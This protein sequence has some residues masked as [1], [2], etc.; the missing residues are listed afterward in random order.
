MPHDASLID[1]INLLIRGG[2]YQIPADSGIGDVFRPTAKGQQGGRVATF[3]TYFDYYINNVPP[4]DE[5]KQLNPNIEYQIRL[6]PDVVA[7][8]N[9]RMFTVASMP[10]RVEANP[11]ASDK[12]AAET[13]AEHCR[14]VIKAI[15]NF[16]QCIEMMEWAV[17]VGGQGLEFLWHKDAN[18]VE[19]PVSYQP[20]HMSRFIFDR[21]GNMA[22]L[23]RDNAV[24]GAYVSLDPQSQMQKKGPFPRGKFVYH[25]YRK[26]QGTWQQPL[27]EGYTYYGYGEDIAI[28]YVV[29]WD[30]F[31]LKMR[32]K[33]LERYGMPPT[34]LYYGQN[35]IMN[36]DVQR[37]ADSLRF[38]SLTTMPFMMA[39]G[40]V[41]AHN[42]LYKVETDQQPSGSMD[43][44]DSHTNGYTKPRIKAIL[45]GDDSA[46]QDATK[47]GHSGDVSKRDAGP[48]IFF[49]RDAQ[50]IGATLTTQ[51]MPA[52]AM[53]RFPNIPRDMWPIFTLEPKEEKDRMQELQI[54]E[55]AQKSGLK[56]T[57]QH[58]YEAA[59]LPVPKAT[60]KLLEA[61]QSQQQPSAPGAGG[62]VPFGM[63]PV[64]GE[65]TP[66]GHNGGMAGKADRVKF[67]NG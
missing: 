52:I 61:P 18:G 5:A 13:V 60:D 56:I 39:P 23:T 46:S 48:N 16:E 8:H 30:I 64:P 62:Q 50:V 34:R 21:L 12:H 49:R 9:Q 19:Y 42:S 41:G 15:P 37:I 67:Q 17:I 63:P 40:N 55:Q 47:S 1:S 10:W 33:F 26:G 25:Q 45:I 32:M 14:K 66:V 51:L 35:Q 65:R 22:L 31:C 28:Y 24:W 20:V 29:T 2:Q 43:W 7:Y 38:E 6:H 36:R 11:D 53:G 59:D 57:E 44:F 58:A 4:P 27:L 54:I 3:E